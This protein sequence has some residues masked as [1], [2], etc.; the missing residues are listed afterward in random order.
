[1]AALAP[2]TAR[3]RVWVPIPFRAYQTETSPIR[4]GLSRFTIGLRGMEQ[5]RDGN[6]LE[7]TFDVAVAHTRSQTRRSG[8]AGPAAKTGS[9]LGLVIP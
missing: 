6:G 1:M 7:V 5:G 4:G 8:P 9:E 3:V 2:P